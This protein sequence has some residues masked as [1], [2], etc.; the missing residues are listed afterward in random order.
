MV[1]IILLVMIITKKAIYHKTS[2][3]PAKMSRPI[4]IEDGSSK[5]KNKA[6]VIAQEDEG[7]N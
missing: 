7:F 1:T 4:P 6:L 3:H 2:Q 5:S